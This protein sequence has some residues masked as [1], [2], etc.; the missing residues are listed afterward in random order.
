MIYYP[1]AV[2]KDGD[3]RNYSGIIP[4]LPG[5][6]PS[7]DTVEELIVE[8]RA[9]AEFHLEGMI[10]EGLEFETAPRSIVEHGKNPNYADA[11]LWA[12]VEVDEDAFSKQ[13]RFNVSWPEYLLKRVDEYAG[14]RHDTRSGFLAK[15]AI[16]MMNQG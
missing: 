3:Q 13:A 14:A 16:K 5:C 9:L 12:V 1:M 15:A 8:A 11:V 6:Y 2:F 10:E 4:D 7:A